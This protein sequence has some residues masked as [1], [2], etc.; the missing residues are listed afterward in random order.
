MQ[1]TEAKAVMTSNWLLVDQPMIDA[2]GQ[3]TLD[4][5]PFHNEPEWAAQNTPYGGAIAFGFLTM[6][7]LTYL[8]NEAAANAGHAKAT[9]GHFL[10]YG[11]DRLRLVAPVPSGGRVRGVFTPG[12]EWA[13]DKGNTRRRMDVVIEIEGSERPALVAEWLSVWVPDAVAA[14]A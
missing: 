9:G 11:F 10:N 13:D 8:A 3:V 14:T 12:D 5:D 1:G 6:S 4:Y 2:F 7:L